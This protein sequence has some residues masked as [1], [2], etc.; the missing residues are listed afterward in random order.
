MDLLVPCAARAAPAP[1][2][3]GIAIDRARARIRV[4]A[5]VRIDLGGIGKGYAADRIAEGL[6]A[7]GAVGTCIAVGGDVRAAGQSPID[8]GPWPIDVEDPCSPSRVLFT[9][10]VRDGGVVT[11]T[12]L[13]RRWQH[14][15][16]WRHHLIDP[17]TGAP[18]EGRIAAVI[19]A[20][21]R[22]WRAEA[23]AKAVFVAGPHE[24]R[25]LLDDQGLRGWI[26]H[27]D[28]RCISSDATR[29]RV[30]S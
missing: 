2:C 4:P 15:G 14:G 8:D 1:G 29:H 26:V 17:A 24:G 23:W 16:R 13:L 19:V 5:G 9:L 10:D 6:V 28:G 18:C 12:R 30:A 20:D 22:T 11:S 27:D 7:R 21:D 25:A 3:A